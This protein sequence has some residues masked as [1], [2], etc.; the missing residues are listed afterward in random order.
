MLEDSPH[1]RE[2]AH[3]EHPVGLV[4]NHNLHGAEIGLSAAEV[5]EQS[6][7]GCDEQIDARRQAT[8][9]WLHANTTVDDGAA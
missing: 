4:K 6:A 7:R 9:L 3:I 8:L 2:K 5:I 1:V